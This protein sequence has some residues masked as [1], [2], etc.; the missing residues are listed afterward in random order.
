VAGPVE[1]IGHY[2]I[3]GTLGEGGMGV[4]YAAHDERLDRPVALKLIST[5]GGDPNSQRRFWREA[6]LAASLNHPA[7][8]QVFEVGESEGRTFIVMERLE[9]EPLQSRLKRGALLPR[10]AV[11]VA[12]GVLAALAMLH[13]RGLVHRD[14]KP[15]NVFLTPHGVKLLDFGLAREVPASLGAAADDATAS[16]LTVA[17]TILGTPHYM[18]PEQVRGEPADARA[19]LFALGVML[20][21]M[22]AGRR[23]FEG[24]SLVEVL[25]ATLHEQPPALGG[26]A[27]VRA[28]DVVVRRALAKRREE[29]PESALR[30][31]EEL[32]ACP[33]SDESG[34]VVQ[35][36]AMR[37]VIVLPFRMLRPDPETE[38]LAFSLPD[39]LTSALSGLD[40]LVVRSSLAAA[41]FAADV[42]D[43]K[44]IA[45]EADVDSVV[46]GTLLRAG[47]Q[48]R[49]TTQLVEAPSGTLLCSDASQA[50]LRDVF[51]LQ[52]EL[53][54]KILRSLSV[55]LS[56]REDRLLRRD[57]PKTAHAYELY[58]RA[59][60][61][62]VEPQGW[63]VARDLYEACLA[64]DSG[65]APAWARLGRVL[66]LLS[67]YQP[68]AHAE[69]RQRAEEAFRRA[70]EL[71]PELPLA[72]SL[73]AQFEVEAGRTRDAVGRLLRLAARH[74]NDAQTFVGL[75][76]AC[77]YAGLLNASLAADR[78][79]R[80]LDPAVRTSV[81]HTLLALLEYER[82][83][84]ADVEDPPFVRNYSLAT[85]G[86]REEAIAAFRE[87]ERHAIALE[88]EV[89][90]SQL[91][92]LEGDRALVLEATARL[93]DSG[94]RDPEG[95]YFAA[96]TLAFIGEQDAALRELEGV[97][98]G[99]FF[100]APFF[101][102]D[103]WLA[104]LRA[105]PRGQ[106]LLARAAALRAEALATYREAG[107]EGLLGPEA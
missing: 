97:I 65:Y 5:G 69:N 25:H 19:D 21:E 79:A 32:A 64:E 91:G 82:A 78:H 71:N 102:R 68:Q 92:A 90:R 83:I 103:P 84:A 66:R 18:A 44:R 96:R 58:L 52:D 42:P 81:A 43:L 55:S 11:Q 41:R 88:R 87:M 22:L 31:A 99:G 34:T 23:P 37:R 61:A 10:E 76:H 2:L 54:Q 33:V 75:V 8:C 60:Q 16:Q 27:G 94:F 20:F 12:S 86:R 17:G 28:V 6:R 107:G 50:T 72:H 106:A 14:L 29:R 63:S 46:S 9:G 7:I 35:A 15:S 4:V 38:F 93:R 74:S 89:G 104:S 77:R 56:A 1:R 40:S 51:Q 73:F 70:L 13:G 67:K 49:V 3:E 98:E 100:C 45:A 85:L 59:N 57:V 26:S 53:L 24:R 62:G 30:M 105:D 101:E 95:L 48:L 80:R 36:R 47:E 39:A